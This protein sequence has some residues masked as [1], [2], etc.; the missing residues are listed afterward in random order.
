MPYAC[1]QACYIMAWHRGTDVTWMTYACM[2][3]CDIMT[4][5]WMQ[6]GCDMLYT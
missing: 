1:M 3:A 6:C 5:A 2:H 4:W